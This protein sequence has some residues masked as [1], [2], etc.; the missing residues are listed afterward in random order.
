MDLENY[1]DR[2]DPDN[3]YEQHLFRAG[4]GLQSAEMNEIQQAS[5]G[6]LKSIGDAIFEDGD[7][8][9][10][11]ACI[12]NADTGAANLNGGALYLRGAVRGVSPG[13]FTVATV[14][15]VAIG[16]YLTEDVVT[17][18]EDPE[19]RDP[20]VGTRNYQEAGAARLQVNTAWGY[21]NDGQA[22]EFYPVWTVIDGVVIPKEPPPNLDAVTNAIAAYDRQSTGGTYVVSGLRVTALADR[23]TGEQVYSV[24]EGEA[25]VDGRNVANSTSRRVVYD[26]IPDLLRVTSE[27]HVSSGIAAQRVNTDRYPL[28]DLITVQITAEKTVTVT[29][30][31]FTGAQD[32]LPDTSVLSLVEVKQGATTYVQGT[33]YKLTAGKVDWSL[34]GAEPSPGST[35]TVKYQYI[36]T[37]TPTGI[38]ASGFTVEGA[39]ASTLIQVTYDT[40]LPRFDRLCLDSSGQFV[41][42]EGV[43]AD[44]FPIAPNV[45]NN[46]LLL[47]TI[48]QTWVEGVTRTVRN[49]GVRVVPMAEIEDIRNGVLDLYDLVAEQKLKGDVSSKSAAAAKGL[50]VDPFRNNNQRD[51]GQTQDAVSASGLLQ[52]P[53]S[54]SV[55]SFTTPGNAP[56]TLSKTD[57]V[58]LSQ[59]LKSSD[60][61]VNPYQ[62]FEPIPA[63]VTL[64][65]AVDNFVQQV[66]A[67]A[68]SII[69]TVRVGGGLALAQS[70]STSVASITNTAL[71]NLRSINVNFTLAG[72]GPSENLTGVIF[73]GIDVTNTVVGV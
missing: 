66:T 19:L 68:P 59:T 44:Y 5:L 60:M 1:Y 27:P 42:V 35:Y 17:E 51:E 16:I 57:A 39:V 4:Y 49:D 45:P 34:A 21:A 73:D 48:S 15:V 13:A 11:C 31:A 36:T 63:R 18:L 61:K 65:P 23:V 29:H 47:A 40:A 71:P 67:W 37:V 8:I 2:T 50:F 24:G 69:Q 7:I 38:D 70:V 43:A 28:H 41:W 9:R 32:G 6:R 3:N 33:D 52:M 12:V 72:F 14:G 22:G 46:L 54:E 20:A 26:A 10:D 53:M 30:G 64:Q 56:A 58:K 55:A 62:A 25:R